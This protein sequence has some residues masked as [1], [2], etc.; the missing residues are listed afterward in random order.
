M[1]HIAIGFRRNDSKMSRREGAVLFH[2]ILAVA[3]FVERGRAGAR[4]GNGGAGAAP[5]ARY[6]P[7]KDLLAYLEFD[8]LDAHADAWHA[9]AAY[10]LLNDTKLGTLLEDLALQAIE[11]FQQMALPEQRVTGGEIVGFVQTHCAQRICPGCIKKGT[12]TLSLRRGAASSWRAGVQT[13]ARD[14]TK[15]RS[16][17]G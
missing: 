8:G 5:L 14:H 11:V 10:K 1:E 4:P 6:V 3:F 13:R 17:R 9:S 15:R 7:L 2:L 12:G 16:S